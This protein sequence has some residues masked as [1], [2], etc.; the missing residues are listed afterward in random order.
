MA[1]VSEVTHE[2][3]CVFN[4]FYLMYLVWL[5]NSNF[6]PALQLLCISYFGCKDWKQTETVLQLIASGRSLTAPAAYLSS[7]IHLHQASLLF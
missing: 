5:N 3:V 1:G 6:L 4:L 2:T 7:L